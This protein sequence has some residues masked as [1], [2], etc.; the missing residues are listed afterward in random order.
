MKIPQMIRSEFSRLWATPMARIAFV[1]LMC[2]PLLYGGLYLWANQDPYAKL[3]QVPVALVVSDVGVQ[4]GDARRT[5]GDEVARNL[6]ED[7]SFDWHR[8]SAREAARGVEDGA[9]DFSVTLPRDFSEAL[10]SSRGD[11]PHRAEV[12]LTTNDANSYLAS[13]IGEQAVKQIRQQVVRSVNQEAARSMLD[14]VAEIRVSLVDARDGAAQLAD[15][16]ATAQDGAHRLADGAQQAHAG[17][18]ELASG[19]GQLRDATAQLPAQSERLA[20]GA[21][22]VADGNAQVAQ[23]G[24]E[25]AGASAQ[26]VDRLA[27]D[28]DAIVAD[29]A[30]AGVDPAVVAAVE[31]RLNGAG[32][33]L[34]EANNRVQGASA[35]LDALASG[36]RQLADGSRALADASPQLASGIASAADG[37]ARLDSGL[38]ELDAGAQTLDGGLGALLDGTAQLRDGLAQGVEQ[39]P[40]SSEELRG[41]QAANI[42]DPVDVR[43]SKVTSAGTYGAG[44]APFFVSL[45]AW[46]GIYALFLILKPVSRR[47]VTALHAPVRVAIAGWATPALL[48]AVQ[49]LALFG[50]VA[51][52]LGFGVT[53]PLPAY[54]FMALASATFAA[55]ILALNVWLGSVGQFLGLVL[56]VLQLV[57]AGGTFPWQTL[58]APLAALHHYL[59]MSFA[60]D[61]LRQLMYGGDLGHAGAD[62]VKLALFLV[63]AVL[64][65]ALGVAR[66]MRSRTL[67]DLQ[68]SLIG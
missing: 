32:A 49:M 59:P 17:S 58:P 57:T 60:V 35:Q 6:I 48:G 50:I 8:V 23:L 33:V 53:H 34:G 42:A 10:G 29:L 15:G 16:A 19:L 20:S 45:A 52:S 67:R 22:Q 41:R 31:Q 62:A 61:G 4:Q 38:A 11:D 14:G 9:Y 24:R 43:T 18:S 44:L 30:A 68:P 47:A 21:A 54:A 51:G 40:D 66:M 27:A 65:A 1:A 64:L 7:G 25:V 28:R 39:I 2:V 13:T 55:I 3:D 12:I 26:A 5:I 37:A 56:M 63:A 36:A 46:I